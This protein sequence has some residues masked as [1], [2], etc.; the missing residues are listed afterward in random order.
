IPASILQKETDLTSISVIERMIWASRRATT[1][2]EDEAYC[3]MGIFS[4]N[5]T[6]LYGEGRQVFYRLQEKIMKRS[7]DTSLFLWG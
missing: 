1:R 2:V 4:I 7:V 6:T 5:M 3:L